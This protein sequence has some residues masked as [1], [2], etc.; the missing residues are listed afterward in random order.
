MASSP[1][2]ALREQVR[3]LTARSHVPFSKRPEAAA[4]LLRDG[5]WVPGVRVES[6]S[7]SLTIPA[8]L[9]LITT[10]I[11]YERLNDLVALTVNQTLSDADRQF[12]GGL[13]AP[14]T[15]VSAED[16]ALWTEDPDS[17]PMPA[18]PLDPDWSA[19]IGTPEQGVQR[20]RSISDRAY[21]PESHFPVGAV[22]VTTDDVHI[23]GV[24]VEHEDWMR[25][26]CAERNALG[27]AY[28][29]GMHD[30][31]AMYLSCPLDD[32]GTPCG[33]C[34]QLLVELAPDIQLWMDRDSNA[35]ERQS[36]RDLLPGS[37]EGKALLR[38]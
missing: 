29:Y 14:P 30:F 21:I 18:D 22:L 7:F 35:P 13:A 17:L 26:L 31:A 5:T 8:T 19:P 34:R 24:N 10:L 4:A 33:A 37:F 16:T 23:P 15:G 9:N 3:T 6:A 2:H 20:A 36:P 11:A 12:L 27:T 25:T 1:L 32:A 28:S 38:S